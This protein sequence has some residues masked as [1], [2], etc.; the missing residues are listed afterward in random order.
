MSIF[1]PKGKSWQKVEGYVKIT[2]Q[3]NLFRPT[4]EEWFYKTTLIP[5]PLDDGEDLDLVFTDFVS[6]DLNSKA[7]QKMDV[8][9]VKDVKI[10]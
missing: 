9:G 10:V 6:Y 8:I 3:N 2:P 5:F 7:V 1:L 4:S